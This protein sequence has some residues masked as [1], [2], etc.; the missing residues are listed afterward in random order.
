MA[1]TLNNIK[2]YKL[3]KDTAYKAFNDGSARI[4][5]HIIFPGGDDTTYYKGSEIEY[6]LAEVG[7]KINLKQDIRSPYNEEAIGLLVE[8]PLE[9]GLITSSDDKSNKQVINK[10]F[11]YKYFITY[12]GSYI[13]NSVS[14]VDGLSALIPEKILKRSLYQ[15]I[16]STST[17]SD[18]QESSYF[19]P[20]T[21]KYSEF[22]HI[23]EKVS[24]KVFADIEKKLSELGENISG[25]ISETNIEHI[26]ILLETAPQI[27]KYAKLLNSSDISSW[28]KLKKASLGEDP[29]FI[30]AT[31]FRPQNLYLCY[32]ENALESNAS[33]DKVNALPEKHSDPISLSSLN[34]NSLSDILYGTVS[35]N[36]VNNV[37]EYVVHSGNGIAYNVSFAF[38][39][40]LSDEEP[41]WPH[42]I[43]GYGINDVFVTSTVSTTGDTYTTTLPQKINDTFSGTLSTKIG[44]NDRNITRGS[45][46]SSTLILGKDDENSTISLSINNSVSGG[47]INGSTKANVSIGGVGIDLKKVALYGTY[48]SLGGLPT[49]TLSSDK[50]TFSGFSS[51]V[52]SFT[53]TS[54]SF[55]KIAKTGKLFDI[56]DKDNNNT[57]AKLENTLTGSTSIGSSTFSDVVIATDSN[58][59]Q[60]TIEIGSRI[61]TFDKIANTAN[62]Q[63][64]NTLP[65]IVENT[66]SDSPLWLTLSGF[67]NTASVFTSSATY[68]I[69]KLANTASWADMDNIALP[70]QLKSGDFFNNLTSLSLGTADND[71]NYSEATFNIYGNST[72]ST[73]SV[74][75]YKIEQLLPKNSLLK[76]VPLILTAS[77]FDTIYNAEIPGFG[78]KEGSN[79][80][81]FTGGYQD[82]LTI[83]FERFQNIINSISDKDNKSIAIRLEKEE[84][85]TLEQESIRNNNFILLHLSSLD[86]NTNNNTSQLKASFIGYSK[87]DTIRY[88]AIININLTG[89]SSS[90]V[91][92]GMTIYW[93]KATDSIYTSSTDG[94]DTH[95]D[96]NAKP[97]YENAAVSEVLN[98]FLAINRIDNL[99]LSSPT[100]TSL[101]VM[102]GKIINNTF[103]LSLPNKAGTI[104]LTSDLTLS[105]VSSTASGVVLAKSL[106]W[107]G[108]TYNLGGT[109]GSGSGLSASVD[110]STLV[111]DNP[112]D[113]ASED[114]IKGTAALQSV[115]TLPDATLST[116]PTFVYYNGGLYCKVASGGTQTYVELKK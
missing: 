107:N 97:K 14:T 12:N 62:Y 95:Y 69:K 73:A 9:S 36:T 50:Y 44:I 89:V 111:I 1:N 34:D 56:T 46:Y 103:D 100:M 75:S 109:G 101:K 77:E 85:S 42:T 66:M 49:I 19:L 47:D 39:N 37:E 54:A 10:E 60:T 74:S 22:K 86:T 81:V 55:E 72:T 91:E 43:K 24:A 25:G 48:S 67:S 87:D 115:S 31:K 94:K 13:P 57:F 88:D 58:S 35:K 28:E 105:T 99:S 41:N 90:N 33:P 106:T 8:T 61:H 65:T 84:T 20:V 27:E 6:R 92:G 76:I 53:S 30:T 83:P 21:F 2:V 78:A 5:D 96:I 68:I 7:K 64:L 112:N 26:Y 80:M 63:D 51:T 52:S 45:S 59:N 11:V 116:S 108:T 71:G 17:T 15:L 40:K 38:G 93:R 16:P 102:D 113:Q 82:S 32:N 79:N 114:A 29:Q 4:D 110:G 70:N 3:R 104:A 18:T 98:N 23:A